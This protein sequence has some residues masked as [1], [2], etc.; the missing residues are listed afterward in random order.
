MK[1]AITSFLLLM[2]VMVSFAQKDSL[3]LGNRYADDQIYVAVSYAQFYDQPTVISKS[4]FS[5]GLSVG[6]I[7]DIILNKQGNISIAAGVGYGFDFFNH[8]LKIQKINNE[9]VFSQDNTISSNLFKSHNLEFPLEF[10]WRTSTAN[11]YSFWRIYGGVKFAYNLSNKFQFDD[12]TQ[13]TFKY[14][15]ISNYN[16]LQYGLTLSAGYDEFNINIYY[17]LTPIFNNSVINGEVI[18]TKILKFGLIFYI[19]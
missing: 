10:R 16:N 5:Y 8:K 12:D 14:S 9:I 2:N 19:L 6:F 13:T 11:K 17:G 15:N 3:E 18:N 7:K 1:T 4:N